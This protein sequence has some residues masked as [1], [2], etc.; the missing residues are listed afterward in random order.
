MG[1]KDII[2]E[3]IGG[4][5]G[6]E[7]KIAET[8]DP[9]TRKKLQEILEKREKKA[10]GLYI[11]IFVIITIWFIGSTLRSCVRIQHDREMTAEIERQTDQIERQIERLPDF[12]PR[13]SFSGT[14]GISRIKKMLQ[15]L[16]SAL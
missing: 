13:Q 7:E 4:T 5:R 1:E 8:K 16:D 9:E 10:H 12:K 3:I 11:F 15:F 14:H 6:L 2:E